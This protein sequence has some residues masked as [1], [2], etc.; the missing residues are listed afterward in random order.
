MMAKTQAQQAI[1]DLNERAAR[2]E[3]S[4]AD[5]AAQVA[6]IHDKRQV[7]LYRAALDVA[8]RHGDGR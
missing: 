5:A 8:A 4:A 1:R 6:A 2:G 3:M 7:A